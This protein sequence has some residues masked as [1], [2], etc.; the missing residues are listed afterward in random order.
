MDA[1]AYGRFMSQVEIRD[2]FGCW[3][4]TGAINENGYGIMNFGGNKY[5]HRLMYEYWT[6]EPIPP[7]HEVDHVRE[8]GC[9]RRD[10]VNPSHLE[11]VTKAENVRRAKARSLT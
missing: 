9:V 5:V 11:C 10:C 4:W 8:R 3:I 6:G 2:L 1:R 7:G